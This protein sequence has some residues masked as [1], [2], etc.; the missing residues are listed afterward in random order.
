MIVQVALVAIPKQKPDLLVLMS[1]G[2]GEQPVQHRAERSDARASR[3]EEGV[4][5]GRVQNE[6]TEWSLQGNLFTFLHVAEK[7]G[8]EPILHSIQTESE[9]I[10]LGWSRA[11]GI[12]TRDFF[13]VSFHM[14]EGKPLPGN[15]TKLGFSDDLKFEILGECR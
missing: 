1:R 7:I 6:V 8:H 2:I 14:P 4:A 5:H 12:G 15:K 9:A 3:N 11:D 10:V 13:S